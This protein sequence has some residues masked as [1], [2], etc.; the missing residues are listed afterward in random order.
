MK[1]EI[2]EFVNEKLGLKVRC[3]QNEDGSISV[4]IGDAAM[5][6]GM[7][8]RDYKKGKEYIRPNMSGINSHLKSFGISDSEKAV[9][10]QLS[11]ST[12]KWGNW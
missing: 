7:I 6:L 2:Q 4:N 8:K 9:S 1:N 10:P 5:G 12:L 3:G 11:N